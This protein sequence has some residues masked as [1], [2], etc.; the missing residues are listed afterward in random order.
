MKRLL[1]ALESVNRARAAGSVDALP[2]DA[3]EA[4]R[5]EI[6][7]AATR[8][9]I[10]GTLAP[11]K[12]NHGVVAPLGG[13]WRPGIVHGTLYLD[14]WGAAFDAPALVWSAAGDEVAVQLLESEALAGDWARLDRFEGDEYLRILV[15]VETDDGV[16]VA[17]LYALRSGTLRSIETGG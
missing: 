17:N 13:S 11:G 7:R 10:Y 8:L 9:A 12:R 5:A 6:A 3:P 1:S 2:A 4:I 14:G 15:P 16:E